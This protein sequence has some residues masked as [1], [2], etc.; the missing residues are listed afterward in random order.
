MERTGGSSQRSAP[1]R[2]RRRGRRP[3]GESGRIARESVR[4]ALN[5]LCANPP[6][7]RWHVSSTL[8]VRRGSA[9][10]AR[11]YRPSAIQPALRHTV[12]QF[13][14]FCSDVS[15]QRE[16]IAMYVTVLGPVHISCD[17]CRS[18]DGSGGRVQVN[19]ATERCT[20]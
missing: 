16:G 17:F 3:V 8:D 19:D 20:V 4:A 2:R 6:A 15:E 7:G 10:A 11:F 14:S 9:Q 18:C 1:S 12:L 5:L 13:V